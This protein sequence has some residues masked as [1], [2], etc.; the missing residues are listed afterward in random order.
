MAWLS[1]FIILGCVTS[2]TLLPLSSALASSTDGP[3]PSVA[4]AEATHNVAKCDKSIAT[5]LPIIVESTMS[6][7]GQGLKFNGD[8]MYMLPLLSYGPC[9]QIAQLKHV[10]ML[11]KVLGR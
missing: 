5:A 9:N 8:K 7:Q 11:S 6:S 1:S 2:S 3:Q 4:A 10:L